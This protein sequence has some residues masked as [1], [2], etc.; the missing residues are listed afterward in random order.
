MTA[1]IIIIATLIILCS[2][3]LFAQTNS[4]P[5]TKKRRFAVYAGIGPNYYFNNLVVG[6]SLV[7]ELNYSFSARLMWEPEHI[8][9][10]GIETGYYRLYS[11]N[12]PE[13]THA[14]IANS[15]IPI[16]LVLSMKFLKNYYFNFSMG[17]S[18]LLNK[19]NSQSYGNFDASTWSL[20]DFSGT[21]GYRHRFKSR[22]SVGGE[23]KFFYSTGFVDRNIALLLV[24]GYKF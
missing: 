22:I 3:D 21:L 9:S 5:V 6:K 15:A 1:R 8:L 24:G 12:T 11:L 4:A 14:H 20:A 7:N 17:Q 16:Q 13:P 10:V 18:I 23:A 2:A 19:V